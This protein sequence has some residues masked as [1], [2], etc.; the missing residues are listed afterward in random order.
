MKEFKIIIVAKSHKL[1]YQLKK[2]NQFLL[3]SCKV[4]SKI[5]ADEL[6]RFFYAADS[7]KH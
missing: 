3:C 5:E 7:F 1:G 4:S 2:Q 6:T